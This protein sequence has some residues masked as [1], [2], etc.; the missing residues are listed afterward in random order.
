MIGI[1][2]THYTSYYCGKREEGEMVGIKG[3]EA[4]VAY[5]DLQI[6]PIFCSTSTLSLHPVFTLST[7]TPEVLLG[8]LG[9]F[10]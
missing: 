3:R 8:H 4:T 9:S 10:S 5:T 6:R 2:P 1:C 7:E